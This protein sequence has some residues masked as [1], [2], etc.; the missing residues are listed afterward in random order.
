MGG[1]ALQR[2]NKDLFSSAALA[3]EVT[4]PYFP[5]TGSAMSKTRAIGIGLRQRP[6]FPVAQPLD[7]YYAALD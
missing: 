4:H 3:A 1:A 5:V 7:S 6:V 2:Y